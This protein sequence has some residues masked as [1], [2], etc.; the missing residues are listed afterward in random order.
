MMAFVAALSLLAG[1]IF[2]LLPF[3]NPTMSTLQGILLAII[4]VLFL[5]LAFVAELNNRLNYNHK[6]LI[7]TLSQDANKNDI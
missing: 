2:I 7:K 4:G 1:I 6:E 5:I 3:L